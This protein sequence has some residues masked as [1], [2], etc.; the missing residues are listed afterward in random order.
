MR[1]R[2]ARARERDRDA[3]QRHLAN[4]DEMR[5]EMRRGRSLAA[6]LG[7]DGGGGEVEHGAR[8]LPTA[9]VEVTEK[10]LRIVIGNDT[11]MTAMIVVV[12]IGRTAA[13]VK[14]QER[15][16]G[17]GAA[18]AR[19]GGGCDA[20]QCQALPRARRRREARGASARL[21]R[22]TN[23][24][25][26][27]PRRRWRARVAT[28][29]TAVSPPCHR[30]V[31]LKLGVGAAPL[32]VAYKHRPA[33]RVGDV[34]VAPY[35]AALACRIGREM[36]D[37]ARERRVVVPARGAIP[38]PPSPIPHPPPPTRHHVPPPIRHA[39]PTTPTHAVRTP[40]IINEPSSTDRPSIH[41]HRGSRLDFVGRTEKQ[42]F[43]SHASRS[44]LQQ[45]LPYTARAPLLLSAPRR[46]T[47]R[48]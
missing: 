15:G 45:L 24:P 14:R 16:E 30:V 22:P 17:G 26:N 48:R 7:V 28:A 39:V 34:A 38:H 47:V 20:H 2:G 10:Q 36:R 1:P 43:A 8:L 12:I 31:L 33:Q 25:P 29:V 40:T 32:V 37:D 35:E 23:R 5:D 18:V 42:D 41:R 4:R 19:C 21:S 46:S 3:P 6:R 44:T 11:M 27:D 13:V 9:V